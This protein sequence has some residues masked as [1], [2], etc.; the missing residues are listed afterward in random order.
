MTMSENTITKKRQ[1][2]YRIDLNCGICEKGLL[3]FNGNQSQRDGKNI[4]QLQ[5]DACKVI[6]E[7]EQIFPQYTFEDK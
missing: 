4:F 2:C 7:A 6:L 5:C 1:Q 3:I